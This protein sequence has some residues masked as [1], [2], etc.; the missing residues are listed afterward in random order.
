MEDGQS[1]GFDTLLIIL[2]NLNLQQFEIH[3][4][5]AF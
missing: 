4:V 1:R 2:S 3:Y 5:I